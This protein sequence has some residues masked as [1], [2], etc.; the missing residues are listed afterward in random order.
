MD[1]NT[2][3]NQTQENENVENMKLNV[4]IHNVMQLKVNLHKPQ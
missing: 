4:Q 2:Y 1:Q 3:E